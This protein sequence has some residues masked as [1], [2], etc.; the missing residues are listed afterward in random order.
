[1]PL[2]PGNKKEIKGVDSKAFIAAP[3]GKFI[4][5]LE[6][7]EYKLRSLKTYKPRKNEVEAYKAAVKNI[8]DEIKFIKAKIQEI[9]SQ[10]SEQAKGKFGALVKMIKKDCGQA[11]GAYQKT[12]AVLFRGAKGNP[13]AYSGRPRTDRRPKDSAHYAQNIFDYCLEK[14]G[15]TALRSN[16]VFAT[17][18]LAQA[19][20]YGTV[21]VLFPKDGFTFTHTNEGDL[22]IND[23]Q[24]AAI[25]DYNKI[26]KLN[27]LLEKYIVKRGWDFIPNINDY[28]DNLDDYID[29]LKGIGFPGAEKL[30]VDKLISL[31]EFVKEF[32]PQ[33]TNF[34]KAVKSG[35]EVIINGEYYAIRHDVG[36]AIL[37]LLGIDFTDYEEG[38]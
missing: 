35:H 5:K 3:T 36:M 16:S 27:D 23:N 1:M 7:L 2:K 33:N 34:A 30:T 24:I 13:V 15:F 6:D 37:P 28:L 14:L 11:L 29:E 20:S 32:Q 21:Y 31:K 8:T 10:N 38:F 25:L 4:R 19:S 22:I 17:Y 26:N 18:D 9:K 12:R